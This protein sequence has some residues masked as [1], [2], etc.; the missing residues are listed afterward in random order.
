MLLILLSILLIGGVTLLALVAGRSTSEERVAESA[1]QSANTLNFAKES[2]MAYVFRTGNGGQGARLGNLPTPDIIDGV[3]SGVS[4]DGTSI[5]SIANSDITGRC[6]SASSATGFPSVSP[7]TTALSINQRCLG[8]FPW[9]DLELGLGQVDPHDPLGQVPWLAISANLNFGD[10]CLLRVNADTAAWTFSPTATVCPAVANAIPYPWLTVVDAAGN[11]ISNR[12]AAVL[13]APGAPTQTTGRAQARTAAAPG[14]PGDYLDAVAVPLGCVSTCIATFDNAN[15]TNTFIQ[16]A[17]GTRFPTNVENTTLAGTLLTSFNDDL[18]YITI[19]EI[20]DRLERRVLAEMKSSL[21]KFQATNAMP[22]GTLGLPW[23]APYA[24]PTND[25]AFS[26]QADTL[27]GMFPFFA[28][29]PVTVG[30]PTAL[31]TNFQWAIAAFQA[32]SKDCRQV[33]TSPNRWANLRQDVITDA[34]NL[35]GNGAGTATWRG[36]TQV[37]L[38]ASGVSLP[39]VMKSF[40]LWDSSAECN[41][42][43]PADIKGHREYAI[44]RTIAFAADITCGGTPTLTYAKGSATSTQSYAWSCGGLNSPTALNMSVTDVIDSPIPRTTNYVPIPTVGGNVTFS[45]L[46]YQPV[47]PAWYFDNE[48]Y[49]TGFYAVGRSSAPGAATACGTAVSLAVGSKTGV[50]AVVMQ[51]GKSL[52]SAARPSMPTADYLEGRNATAPPDCTFEDSSKLR[53]TVYN[54]QLMVVSP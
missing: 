39:I 45:N 30:S 47:M 2:L 46:R 12:V 44:N 32:L 16:I 22:S 24:P 54:D 31:P 51:A 53:S 34:R 6:L 37:I 21:L 43:V 26:A 25:A 48:W 29:H 5:L 33:E 11:V 1:K 7:G 23:A 19:D 28:T 14:V 52:S 42:G 38:S 40:A 49:K 27:V 8:K 36:T 9:R 4:Y 35:A 50:N 17:P 13:I 18:V 10:A 15:L 20:V 3:G 41:G